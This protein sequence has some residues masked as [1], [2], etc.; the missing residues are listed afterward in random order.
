MN[1]LDQPQHALWLT[2]A[3]G[4]GVSARWSA[5]LL[6]I[7]VYLHALDCRRSKLENDYRYVPQEPGTSAKWNKQVRK[8]T[9]VADFDTILAKQ[10]RLAGFAGASAASKSSLK[11]FLMY[12]CVVVW[13]GV[14]AVQRL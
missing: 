7:R 8:L 5:L 9:H 14:V 11:P 3:A 6:L 2:E 13:R 12:V 10:Y 4:A 1:G